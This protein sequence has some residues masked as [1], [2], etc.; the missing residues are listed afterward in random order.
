MY[1]AYRQALAIVLTTMREMEALG[2]NIPQNKSIV[3]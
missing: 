2:G 3:N 1:A